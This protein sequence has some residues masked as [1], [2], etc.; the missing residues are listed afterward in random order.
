MRGIERMPESIANK[1]ESRHLKLKNLICLCLLC[2]L[3]ASVVNISSAYAQEEQKQKILPRWKWR[4]GDTFTYRLRGDVVSPGAEVE[5]S[6]VSSSMTISAKDDDLAVFT[7]V[8]T[9]MKQF[10]KG[11]WYNATEEGLKEHSLSFDMDKAGSA[12]GADKDA[13]KGQQE[14]LRALMPLPKSAVAEGAAWF[15]S[16]AGAD[17]HGTVRL[18]G[19][20]KR[21]DRRCAIF[22]MELASTEK[23]GKQPARELSATCYFDLEE[24]CFVYIERRIQTRGDK[25][26]DEKLTLELVSSPGCQSAVRKEQIIIDKLL[27]RLER[28]PKDASVM[29]RLSDHYARLGKLPEALNMIDG[30]LQAEPENAA[31][32]TRKGELMFASGDSVGALKHFAKVLKKDKTSSGALLG[33]ANACFQLQ[34]YADCARYARAVLGEES[35]GPYKGYYLLGAALAK[36]GKKEHAQKA[37]ERYVELNPNIDKNHKPVIGF[38]KENDVRIVVQRKT[39]G[40]DVGKR[41]KYTPQELAEGREL[42]KA[43]VKEESV[44]LRLSAQEIEKLLDFLATLYGKKATEMIADFMADRDKTYERV[45]KRLEAQSKLPQE[46]IGKLAKGREDDPAAMEAVL[47]LLGPAEA[48]GILE[49]M[50]QTHAGEARYHYLLGR[51]YISNP[52]ELGRKALKRFELAAMLDEKN[53]LYRYATAYASLKIHNQKRALDELT[54]KKL[55]L[56]APDVKRAVIAR[57]RLSVLEKVNFNEKIRKVTAWTLDDQFEARIVKE[58]LDAVLSIAKKFRKDRLYSA[59]MALAKFAYYMTQQLEADAASALVLVTARSARETALGLIVGI[60]SDA[61][62]DPEAPNGEKYAA[63]LGS[64]RKLLAAVEEQNLDYL[65]AYVEFLKKCEKA[66]QVQPYTEPS[67]SDSFIEKVMRGEVA[68]FREELARVIK[69]RQAVETKGKT[70]K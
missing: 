13:V 1:P 58:L 22:K 10:E 17:M 38:T 3:C 37:L 56:G 19:Y 44:R 29:R 26:R 14:F 69:G 47:S 49:K 23:E 50:V 48:A 59:G 39:P 18:A 32:L 25:R 9:E 27:E 2:V 54:A 46:A 65:Q 20:G 15:V 5:R 41:E 55:V 24:G 4:K 42:I 28:D 70:G 12:S 51:Y 30:I 43:L 52:K 40:V 35:K 60:S 33:A 8:Y 7:N 16:L 31:A 57:E 61:A 68:A 67:E 36:M 53:I 34:R 6:L 21:A 11:V 63:E 66:F 62:D 45:S 64:W